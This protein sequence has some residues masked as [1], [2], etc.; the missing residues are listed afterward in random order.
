[1]PSSAH[2]QVELHIGP[3]G[4]DVQNRDRDRY[5]DPGYD[6]GPRRRLRSA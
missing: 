3:G 4:V 1:M 5:V 2:A 6:R